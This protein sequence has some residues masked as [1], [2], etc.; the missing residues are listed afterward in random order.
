[1]NPQYPQ[2]KFTIRYNLDTKK[3]YLYNEKDL[4]LKEDING[5]ELAREAWDLGADSVCYDYDLNI[6]EKLPLKPL[7]EKYKSR[8]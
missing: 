1:M 4:C 2:K 5:R 6:D 3:F 7:H 8:S